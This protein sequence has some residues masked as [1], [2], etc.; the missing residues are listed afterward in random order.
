MKGN[1]NFES[2]SGLYPSWFEFTA[3]NSA[4]FLSF[5]TLC[6]AGLNWLFCEIWS[7]KRV[8]FNSDYKFLINHLILRLCVQL[9]WQ[10]Q[11]CLTFVI[12]ILNLK[13]ICSLIDCSRPKTGRLRHHRDPS[14]LCSELSLE[15]P[16]NPSISLAWNIFTAFNAKIYTKYSS[17]MYFSSLEKIL[18]CFI[19][20][21]FLFSQKL[22]F[23]PQFVAVTVCLMGK[24]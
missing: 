20:G 21:N 11:W 2:K 24:A 22:L 14:L 9:E 1:H 23:S 13:P 5:R 15:N 4:F 6:D 10:P 18:M 16:K 7:R 12:K 17:Y 8:Q 3:R 19:S